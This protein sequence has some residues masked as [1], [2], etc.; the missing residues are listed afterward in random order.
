MAPEIILN[1]KPQL[2]AHPF[3]CDVYSYA[4]LAWQVLSGERPYRKDKAMGGFYIMKQV[5]DGE[6]PA[7]P[8]SEVEA[9]AAAEAE[10]DADTENGGAIEA[11][12]NVTGT[13]GSGSGSGSGTPWPA[14]A[15]A[16]IKKCWAQDPAERP[17]F[18]MVV[19]QLGDS[20][21]RF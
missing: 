20:S 8:F 13:G 11:K 7:F 6:R 4:I 5:V 18:Q 14:T 9:A 16:L 10:A 3:A 12:T 2:D 21:G 1:N 19:E 15:T 17:D